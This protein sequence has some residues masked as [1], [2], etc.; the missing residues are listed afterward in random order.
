MGLFNS[1]RSKIAGAPLPTT[2]HGFA[3]ITRKLVNDTISKED[4]NSYMCPC[5]KHAWLGRNAAVPSACPECEQQRYIGQADR[6]Q[7]RF[8]TQ[9]VRAV[10]ISLFERLLT[11]SHLDDHVNG[12]SNDDTVICSV[13][14][15]DMWRNVDA[16]RVKG[17]ETFGN[18]PF[19]LR[20]QLGTDGVQAFSGN[21]GN[22]H[23]FWP[24]IF[25]IL[26]VNASL[27]NKEDFL[28]YLG[29]SVGATPSA[30]EYVVIMLPVL[31]WFDRIFFQEGLL[32][33]N[34]KTLTEM[35]IKAIVYRT[36]QDGQGISKLYCRKQGGYC[37]CVWCLMR[38][39]QVCTDTGEWVM[40]TGSARRLL[41]KDSM[42][43]HLRSTVTTE[44][45]NVWNAPETKPAPKLKDTPYLVGQMEAIRNIL[46]RKDL[47][48]TAVQQEKEKQRLIEAIQNVSGVLSE[49]D[50]F[51]EAF[52]LYWLNIDGPSRG[53]VWD[54]MH[55]VNNIGVLFIDMIWGSG[56]ITGLSDDQVPKYVLT[57]PQR[58]VLAQRAKSMRFPTE[59][60]G[61]TIKKMLTEG[62]GGKSIDRMH[63]LASYIFPFAIVG[64]IPDTPSGE[65]IFSM[66]ETICDVIGRY[67]ST[68][69][70]KDIKKGP[71]HEVNIISRDGT[72][73]FERHAHASHRGR[74]LQVHLLTHG[75]ERGVLVNGP[76]V[77][78][79]QFG[80]ER[81]MGRRKRTI[82][83]RRAPEANL[84][85]TVARN[86][87]VDFYLLRSPT[88]QETMTHW[89]Q[90]LRKQEES[91]VLL[92]GGHVVLRGEVSTK[93]KAIILEDNEADL[94]WRF[95]L[96]RR[97]LLRSLYT[98][99]IGGGW[100]D[101]GDTSFAQWL[102]AKDDNGD[103]PD[104]CKQYLDC[105]LPTVARTFTHSIVGGLSFRIQSRDVRHTTFDCGVMVNSDRISPHATPSGALPSATKLG[106][107]EG[108]F[109]YGEIV[110]TILV[111]DFCG[112]GLTYCVAFVSWYNNI[113]QYDKLGLA[114]MELA[115]H[116]NNGGETTWKAPKSH[117][118]CIDLHDIHCKFFYGDLDLN[119]NGSLRVPQHNASTTPTGIPARRAR[120]L[121]PMRRFHSPQSPPLGVERLRQPGDNSSD[122][123]GVAD[124]EDGE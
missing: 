71:T 21:W 122:G 54:L 58:Q 50:V 6:A 44:N 28:I 1:L 110:K 56:L 95:I 84:H 88:V 97:P 48:G 43:F 119:A 98:E 57:T 61:P 107:T 73:L 4:L 77:E 64:L 24:I 20:L 55:I 87:A 27:R 11:A 32:V 111:E 102:S 46:A 36:G 85:N 16:G 19:N 70:P 92:S 103:L 35:M 114:S 89:I 63:L 62:K 121:L 37:A 104:A 79:W 2:R 108:K 83:L 29:S 116:V 23:T 53:P 12:T 74:G 105:E 42:F 13:W 120:I 69:W 51:T 18:N 101:G 17:L 33:Q 94:V 47:P 3:S 96:S 82:H 80:A 118:S 5:K 8:L 112:D 91:G 9:D 7:L 25:S 93:K 26:N 15:T 22:A 113:K 99:F 78:C 81:D 123:G 75:V 68:T 14:D 72:V 86:T 100:D 31:A 65:G 124:D 10:V 34:K 109:S 45:N 66:F 30:E 115:K 90:H 49:T 67:T 117:M 52:K 40:V 76:P 59:I 60:N 39:M 106:S 38:N 41:T